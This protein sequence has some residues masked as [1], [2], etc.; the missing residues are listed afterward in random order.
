MLG[1]GRALTLACY[2]TVLTAAQWASADGD[3]QPSD[4]KSLLGKFDN[5][6][7]VGQFTIDRPG[8]EARPGKPERYE[9]AKVLPAAGGKYIVQS[10]IKYGEHDVT[11]PVPVEMLPGG[12][13]TV[14]LTLDN[15]A[16]PLLGEQFSAR[17]V[18]DFDSDRYA[19]TW[20]HGKVGGHMWGQ[21]EL[22]GADEKSA[23]KSE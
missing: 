12:K 19:G 5:L 18:F 15:L 3:P 22:A 9:I 4:V 1:Y 6:T 13:E 8:Q 20:K 17:V 23:G 2:A 11:V 10:R 7:L 16:I 21:L 14:V